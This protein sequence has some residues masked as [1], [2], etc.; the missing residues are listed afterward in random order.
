MSFCFFFTI[1]T[2]FFLTDDKLVFVKF[3]FVDR[4]IIMQT[5][6]IICYANNYQL[7]F[8][9]K[10]LCNNVLDFYQLKEEMD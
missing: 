8:E 3:L 9:I 5:Y 10:I 2:E 6:K 7:M 1:D 4:K